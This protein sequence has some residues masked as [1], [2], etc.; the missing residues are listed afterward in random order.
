MT[1][2]LTST[3]AYATVVAMLLALVAVGP[4]AAGTYSR[5]VAAEKYAHKLLNC[6]RTGGWVN[7]HG[8]CLAYGSGKF[9]AKRPALRLHKN[10]SLKVAWPWARTMAAKQVC[11]HALPGK[12]KLAQRMR[13]KGFKYWTYG[14]NVG[15]LWGGNDA[16]AVVLMVHRMMQAEKSS[17]GG[18]WK[19]MKNPAYKSVGIG[20]AK[21][22]GRITV[23]WDFYGKKY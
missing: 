10:I 11:A 23:V 7:K 21:G 6:T 14:E 1:R 3:V 9:S 15:C 20:V 13:S 19:N 5:D 18:H 17:K 4:V 22:D 16:K 12:P 2:S 8:K